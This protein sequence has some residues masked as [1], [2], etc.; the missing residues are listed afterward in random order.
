MPGAHTTPVLMIWFIIEL[1]APPW[2][3]I[4]M[5]YEGSY[6]FWML[7]QNPARRS[8]VPV[9]RQRTQ[10]KVQCL[11]CPPACCAARDTLCLPAHQSRAPSVDHLCKISQT[12]GALR[13]LL[14]SVSKRRTTRARESGLEI[15]CVI[16]QSLSATAVCRA[17]IRPFSL[18]C[19]SLRPWMIPVSGYAPCIFSFVSPCRTRITRMLSHYNSFLHTWHAAT[20]SWSLM[21]M[22]LPC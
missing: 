3:T 16:G 11:Q 17:C 15:M 2:L 4:T 13:W 8:A 22:C 5:V 19:V 1:K 20:V 10:R 6:S 9:S 18:S 7:V 14:R 12:Y 21:D